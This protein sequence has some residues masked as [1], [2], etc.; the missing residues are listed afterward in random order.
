[1]PNRP[2][3]T[4]RTILAKMLALTLIPAI[5]L[6]FGIGAYFYL[7]ARASLED[8]MGRRL[9]G[10][11]RIV[12]A[13]LD[14]TQV[15]YYAPG[16]ENTRPYR[17]LTARLTP[18]AESNDL[19]RI[20]V[21]RPDGAIMFDSDPAG[22]VG[23]PMYQ[24]AGHRRELKRVQLRQAVSSTMFEGRD[25]QFYKTGYA[26]LVESDEVVAVVGVEAGVRFFSRLRQV[27]RNLVLF[28][29]GGLLVFAAVTIAFARR[30]AAPIRRL[31]ASAARIGA[32]DYETPI[33]PHGRDEI[34]VLAETLNDM[35]ARIVER[36]RTLQMMQ[37][38]IAHEV[39][40]PLGGMELYCDILTDELAGRPDL[41]PHVDKIR[42][43]LKSLGAVVNEFLDFTREHTPDLRHVKVAEYL[44][45]LLLYYAGMGETQNVRLIAEIDPALEAAEFDPDLI[46]RTLH[47]LL[48]NA[49][50]AMPDGGE[51]RVGVRGGDGGLEITIDDTGK[52]L[53]PEAETNLFT[54]FF[55]TKEKGTG[56]GLPLARKIVAS[57]GGQLTL[58]RKD[59]PGVSVRVTLP[60]P[61]WKAWR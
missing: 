19:S 18:L 4:R 3:A 34:G 11:A 38:G 17:T 35:R 24:L 20:F 59:G 12:A 9:V 61:G 60:Q 42:G 27:G 30:L 45:E 21:V 52:G 8:E 5:L 43:E 31:A 23:E 22:R 41:L 50:Q 26:P 47:N 6:L 53:T 55:T 7:Q 39:R 51:L 28:S 14:P 2:L 33:A 48:L 56:L 25:G 37:R 16:D 32:G 29:L 54:P 46:R 49:L 36:D 10:L 57:H 13:E 15:L 1:M 44:G 40:N 58:R